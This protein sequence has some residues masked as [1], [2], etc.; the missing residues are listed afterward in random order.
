[1]S[2]HTSA[3]GQRIRRSRIARDESNSMKSNRAAPT[4][5]VP[6]LT[7]AANYFVRL[8]LIVRPYWTPTIRGIALSVLA[9]TIGLATPYLSKLYFDTVYP[10]RDT[11]LMHALV[12]GVA[13]FSF[14]SALLGALRGYYTQ[15]VSAKVA[16]AV[17]LMFFNHLQHLPMRFFEEHRVGEIMSRSS[18]MRV[19]LGTIARVIQTIL[20]NGVY[21]VIVP[22][23]LFLL[24]WKLAVVAVIAT[25]IT[26]V[27][28]TASSRVTRRFMKRAAEAGAELNATQVEAIT[29]VRTLK[30]MAAEPFVFR[31]SV[32]QTEETLRLQLRTA[33]LGAAVGVINAA[34]RTA[35]VAVF[36][37]YAW[38]LIL[39]GEMSLG[40]F[41]AF[42]AYMGYLTGPVGQVTGLFADFQQSAVALGRAFEYLDLTTEQ[43]PEAAYVPRQEI[44]SR[45]GGMIEF[46][47]VTFGYAANKPVLQSVSVTFPKGTVTAV[48]GPSGAGKSTILKLLCAMERPWSGAILVDGNPLDDMSL[49]DLRRQLAVVWQDATLLRGSVWDNITLGMDEVD[50]GVVDEAVRTCR[51]DSVIEQLPGGYSEM[52]AECGATLSGGQRQRF[53]LARALVRNAPVLLLDE[54][55]S[56]VDVRTEDEILRELIPRVRDRT[57]VLVT[58]RIATASLADRICVLDNG[59]V[60]GIGTH[61][62]LIHECDTYRSLVQAAHADEGKRLRIL[63]IV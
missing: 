8:L 25:P 13:A 59:T 5:P 19:S 50:R 20:V 12:L 54:T 6:S 16:S 14:A 42:S 48:V 33:G 3:R 31:D 22:P 26:A 51:L 15:V 24:N 7:D 27:V 32:N 56:Q 55:T 18:D 47:N 11:S 60:A 23:L 9:A 35:G 61:D 21:L 36:T 2:S 41:V 52:I 46:R 58:H 29:Q 10:A 63:G 34:I 45:I 57:V 39:R 49:P 17:S 37:W 1:M 62:E 43:D 44:R 53:A 28:S 30:A 38:T 40:T 4:A